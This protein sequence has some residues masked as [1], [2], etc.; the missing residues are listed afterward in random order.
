MASGLIYDSSRLARAYAFDRPPIHSLLLSAA[1]PP[2]VLHALD[3]G[4]GAG[5]SAA[6]LLPYAAEVFGLEPVA[7]MLTHH[8]TVAPGVRFIL[9]QAEH[10]PFRTGSFELVAAAGSLNYASL[11]LALPEIARVLAPGGTFV[12][13]D[14]GHGRSPALTG[15]WDT[16]AERYPAS[17]GYDLDQSLFDGWLPRETHLPLKVVHPMTIQEFIRYAMSE[18]NVEEALRAG[19]SEADILAWCESAL[20]P[21]FHHE[22]MEITFAGYVSTYR[23]P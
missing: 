17:P 11:P 5:L 16:F 6:A 21:L 9:G 15:W 8:A 23:R 20:P 13:Y 7:R 10:L 14:F 4:S 12:L 22:P 1:S 18:T 2:S 19:V 3:I